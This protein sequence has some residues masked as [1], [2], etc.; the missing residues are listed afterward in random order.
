[1]PEVMRVAGV[2]RD[3]IPRPPVQ[4]PHSDVDATGIAQCLV[5]TVCAR[6]NDA[7]AAANTQHRHGLMQRL[8]A[9]DGHARAPG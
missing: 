7:Q 9:P 2:A 4:S 3:A 6:I 5:V 1:V 8:S